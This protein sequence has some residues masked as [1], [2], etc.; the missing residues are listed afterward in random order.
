[1]TG[2]GIIAARSGAV[3]FPCFIRRRPEGGHHVKIGAPLPSSVDPLEI[4]EEF[5]GKLNR[6]FM[7]N[8]KSGCGFSAA[9]IL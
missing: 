8:L 4:T 5:K 2:P 3:V 6:L 7:K 1:M 9:G